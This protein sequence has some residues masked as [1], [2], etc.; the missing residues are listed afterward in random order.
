MSTLNDGDEAWMLISAALVQ[1]MTPAVGLFYGA[2]RGEVRGPCDASSSLWH[3]HG[4]SRH[5]K[6]ETNPCSPNLDTSRPTLS[7]QAASWERGRP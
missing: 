6:G 2:S 4:P 3:T 1:L 7:S 5:Q